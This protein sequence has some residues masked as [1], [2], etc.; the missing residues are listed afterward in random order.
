[1]L[2]FN[3]DPDNDGIVSYHIMCNLDIYHSCMVYLPTFS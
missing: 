2:E 3:W 1:M